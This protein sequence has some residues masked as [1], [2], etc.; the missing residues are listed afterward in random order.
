M[1][2]TTFFDSV[3]LLVLST[4]TTLTISALGI[5]IGFAIALPVC[6][7]VLSGKAPLVLLGR[8]YI[9]FFRGVPLLVQLLLIYYLLPFVGL[10]LPSFVAGALGLGAC[11]A[12][13]QAENI[14][15]GFLAVPKG[16]AEAAHAMGYGQL[17]T[18]RNILLP[19]A[20]RSA[21]PSIV[22]EMIAILKA[23]SLVSVVGVSE[24]T[25]VAQSIVARTY[26]PL[27]WYMMAAF[28]YLILNIALSWAANRSMRGL[29]VSVQ[30]FRL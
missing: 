8:F 25:R 7:C 15:G 22:N 2:Q 13:Y 28:L 27:E 3:V 29:T 30:E 21:L 12:A 24:L 4:G 1:I 18:W 26:Q 16:Q 14:R 9:S 23:S 5:A 19:Q 6:A 20:F 11:T 17:Q 10:E